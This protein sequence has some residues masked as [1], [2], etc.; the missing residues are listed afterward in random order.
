MLSWTDRPRAVLDL[1]L[2]SIQGPFDRRLR[3][4]H[5]ALLTSTI[6]SPTNGATIQANSSV[7][8]SGTA[9][10]IGGGVVGGVEVS[11]DNGT[12]WHPANGRAN[13]T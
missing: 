8:I 4:G 10:D 12:T 6:T 9:S 1:T 2:W 3:L 7:T 13:W 5:R 11:V